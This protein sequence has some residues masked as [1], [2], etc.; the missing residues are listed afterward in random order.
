MS[1]TAINSKRKLC[2]HSMSRLSSLGLLMSKNL[3]RLYQNQPRKSKIKKR[4]VIGGARWFTSL[5]T[6]LP[7]DLPAHRAEDFW[8]TVRA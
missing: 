6:V 1:K 8:T 7:A 3:P 5:R 4:S 2:H